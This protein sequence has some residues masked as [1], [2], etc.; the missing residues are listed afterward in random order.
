[1]TILHQFLKNQDQIEIKKNWRTNLTFLNEKK[2][3]RIIKPI[4][5][6]RT[7]VEKV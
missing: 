7:C 2:T 1:M 5:K 6:Y 3:K 4:Q